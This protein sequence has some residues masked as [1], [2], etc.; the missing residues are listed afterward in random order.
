[1]KVHSYLR[2]LNINKTMGP[3][4]VHLRVLKELADAVAEPFSITSEKS[5]QSCEVPSD[6]KNGN[7]VPTFKKGKKE[8]PGNYHPVSL[9]SV[10]GKVMGQILL[11]DML[12]HAKAREVI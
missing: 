3:D 1:D 11:E 5:W 9:S 2:N 8:D 4:G 6:W 7:I 12:R 10:P